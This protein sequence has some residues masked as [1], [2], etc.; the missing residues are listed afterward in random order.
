MILDEF[1]YHAI[2]FSD[3]LAENG[4]DLLIET[5]SQQTVTPCRD[6]AAKKRYTHIVRV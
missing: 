3:N 5:S 6:F 4:D 1:V 2:A